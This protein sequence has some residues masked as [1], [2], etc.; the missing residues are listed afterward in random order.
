M[1]LYKRHCVLL[2]R[3]MSIMAHGSRKHRA[4]VGQEHGA[5]PFGPENPAVHMQKTDTRFLDVCNWL[6]SSSTQLLKCEAAQWGMATGRTPESQAWGW[7]APAPTR[8]KLRWDGHGAFCR[9]PVPT[10]PEYE[11]KTNVFSACFLD[12]AYFSCSLHSW[13]VNAYKG[14]VASNSALFAISYPD[15]SAITNCNLTIYSMASLCLQ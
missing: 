7:C 8:T 11:L 1:W 3:W 6:S 14:V 5:G 13:H 10:L 9:D 15:E 12:T 4:D 2:G